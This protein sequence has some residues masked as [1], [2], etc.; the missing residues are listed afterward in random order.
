MNRIN[1]IDLFEITLPKAIES[2]EK[3]Y[4]V[5][6]ALS[7]IGFGRTQISLTIVAA[8]CLLGINNEIMG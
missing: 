5:D 1:S 8:I 3:K 2:N 4:T 6:E 7:V